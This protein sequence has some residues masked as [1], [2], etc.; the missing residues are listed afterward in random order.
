[1]HVRDGET[2]ERYAATLT[3]LQDYAACIGFL[4]HYVASQMSDCTHKAYEALERLL[5]C[6]AS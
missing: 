3:A 1:M 2:L 6:C 4:N 5:L